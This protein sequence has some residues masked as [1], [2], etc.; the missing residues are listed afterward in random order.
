MLVYVLIQTPSFENLNFTLGA[1]FTTSGGFGSNQVSTIL[2]IGMFLSFYAWMNKILFSGS[3]RIDGLF[4]AI[5]AY[6]GFLTFSRGGM[7]IAILCILTYYYLLKNS[8]NYTS[9]IN[10]RNIKPIR[11][12][13]LGILFVLSSYLLINI[14]SDNKITYRYIGETETTLSGEKIKTLNTIST[15]R[16]D[17]I[18][19]DFK[20]WMDNIIFGTGAGASKFLRH[21][22]LH[23]YASHTEFS[24]LLAEHGLFGLMFIFLLMQILY[25]KYYH[26][27]NTMANSLL[28]AL[29]LIGIGTMTHSGMRT[30]VPPVFLALS[31]MIIIKKNKDEVLE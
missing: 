30:F 20:L 21:S 1:N 3:H 22:R 11:F 28:I 18:I 16:Y 17:I 23:G 15:G 27:K 2:G 31:T 4:I 14:I 25:K 10:K 9:F 19:E 26:N 7:V 5:F 24:R 8:E 6:Q 29:Y 13:T 12:F